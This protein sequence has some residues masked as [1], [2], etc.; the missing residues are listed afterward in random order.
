[1]SDLN[2]LIG[3]ARGG[4]IIQLT[5]T[6]LF[7]P[8]FEL[9]T[10]GLDEITGGEG[11]FR[12]GFDSW[13]PEEFADYFGRFVQAMDDSGAHYREFARAVAGAGIDPR[14]FVL[15]ITLDKSL[16]ICVPGGGKKNYGYYIHR[17]SWFDLSP[18][19]VNVVLYLTDVSYA[20]NTT[21]FPD[22][23]GKAI[24]YDPPTRQLLQPLGSCRALAFNSRA[25]DC[26]VFA[27]DQLHGGA[28]VESPRLSVEFRVSRMPEFGRPHQGIVYHRVADFLAEGGLAWNR[29]LSATE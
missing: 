18:D 28:L 6:H 10:E 19:G 2:E 8:V 24:D 29:V 4:E 13:R 27:G 22:F 21:F 3:R 5:G 20:G 26:L 1:M 23:F 16:R 7:T 12:R 25:G 9:L 17:D 15:F 14:E 11:S